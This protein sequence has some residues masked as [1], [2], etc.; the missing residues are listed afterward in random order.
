MPCEMTG[1]HFSDLK[2]LLKEQTV[3][4]NGERILI[5]PRFDGD[6]IIYTNVK[7]TS[8]SDNIVQVIEKLGSKIVDKLGYS[9]MLVHYLKVHVN[10]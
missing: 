7:V 3:Y 8:A 1:Q 5:E 4:G 9:S 6:D 10:Y 2:I